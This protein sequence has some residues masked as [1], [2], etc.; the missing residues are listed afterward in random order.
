MTASGQSVIIFMKKLIVLFFF[1]A[2]LSIS[3]QNKS[4]YDVIDQKMDAIPA[5]ATTSTEE[6]ASYISQNFES[7]EDK[8]RA[9]YYWTA[10][11]IS[12]DVE[13]MFN[14]PPNQNSKE[15]IERTLTTR[16]GVC[17][18]YAEV[19]SSITNQLQIQTILIDGYTKNKGKVDLISHVWCAAKIN[20][21]WCLY[22][23]T[24]GAGYVNDKKFYKKLND[25]Y[26]NTNPKDLILN[27]MPF[28]YMWQLYEYPLS[29]QEFYDGLVT[30]KDTSSKF[31]FNNEIE[32]HLKLSS[33]DKCNA[34]KNR[35]QKSG[36]K[37]K[38]IT[39][40]YQQ[41]DKEIAFHNQKTSGVEFM[42]VAQNLTSTGNLFNEFIKFRNNRFIPSISDDDLRNK[43][44]ELTTKIDQCENDASKIK[45]VGRDNVD[46]LSKL[47]TAIADLKKHIEEQNKF[48]EEYISKDSAM[49]KKMFV[50]VKRR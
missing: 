3:G 23:P 7:V 46:N 26:Y 8:I 18:H 30:S 44:Q 36:F 34:F 22:D 10:A 1:I 40:R 16:K 37:N 2:S 39:E 5:N 47:K 31:D 11:N 33:I 25:F 17:M 48:V 50:V 21:K 49:R 45:N 41:L 12:Y 42:T 20:N 9:A 38:L 24:W 35:I 14:L 43:T 32:T 4:N 28:D 27:H 29:N 19:F 15:K 13:N 6:I